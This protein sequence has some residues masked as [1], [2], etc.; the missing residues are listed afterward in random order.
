MSFSKWFGSL[1]GESVQKKPKKKHG[2]WIDNWAKFGATGNAGTAD[3]RIAYSALDLNEAEDVI[4]G[5]L[6]SHSGA[7]LAEMRKAFASSYLSR[8]GVRNVSFQRWDDGKPG[9]K[10]AFR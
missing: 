9:Y 5:L 6:R 1:F 2:E 4:R 3:V 7:S 10:G 8:L